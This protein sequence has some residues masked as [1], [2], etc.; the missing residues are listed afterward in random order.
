MD[1]PIRS[2]IARSTPDGFTGRH[3]HYDGLPVLRIP[4]LM[5][6]VRTVH[7]GDARAVADSLIDDHPG[8]W[9]TIPS[10]NGDQ[11]E[12][13]CHAIGMPAETITHQ[14]ATPALHPWIYIINHTHL[15]VLR[16]DRNRYVHHADY[17]WTPEPADA[18]A[19]PLRT[20]RV[21]YRDRTA[22]PLLL[23]AVLPTDEEPPDLE[24]DMWA[25]NLFDVT[26]ESPTLTSALLAARTILGAGD[27]GGEN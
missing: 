22:T 19:G 10:A 23:L 12:C 26:V 14:S 9:L 7:Q 18:S 21:V 20:W 8:G 27:Q 24:A 1:L 25:H 4:D 3:V 17:A 5:H 15:A 13:L 16:S 6:L 11:G 2:V